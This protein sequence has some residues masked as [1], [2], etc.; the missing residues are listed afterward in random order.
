MVV[1]TNRNM[2]EDVIRP[3]SDILTTN[4]EIQKIIDNENNYW[5]QLYETLH[6]ITYKQKNRSVK[7]RYETCINVDHSPHKTL[8]SVSE[9]KQIK[10][11]SSLNFNRT[12][13]PVRLRG[14]LFYGPP[15]TGKTLVARALA[16][17]CSNGNR[18]VAFFMRKGADC[19][20]KWVG[21]SERQLRLLFEQ[22][23]PRTH[24]NTP[25]VSVLPPAGC[26]Q[27]TDTYR[28]PFLFWK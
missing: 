28:F 4:P 18:K 5:L 8:C 26:M 14:C 12:S 22:V 3:F 17:E 9:T 2:F 10:H 6:N 13:S 15:G 19:L 20:S 23:R 16:N 11:N 24:Q 25:E 27:T 1:D 21:E 7:F